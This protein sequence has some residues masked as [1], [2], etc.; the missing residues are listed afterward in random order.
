[1]AGERLYTRIP[2]EST[3]DRIRVGHTAII[4]Y[5]NL[6]GGQSFKNDEF[7]IVKNVGGDLEI[8]VHDVIQTS[9]TAG[10]IFIHY[11]HLDEWNGETVED[12]VQIQDQNGT[13]I[14]DV[15]GTETPLYTNVTQI[16][17]QVNPTYG[18]DVDQFVKDADILLKFGCIPDKLL[19][20]V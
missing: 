10:Q 6:Q 18:V 11:E 16:V 9:G 7:Y 1:M 15:N 3:G 17:G 13:Y 12:G 20:N 4:A 19:V 14:A 2:P 8:H 5:D